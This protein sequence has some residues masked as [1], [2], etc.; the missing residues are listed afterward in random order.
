MN[1]P[2]TPLQGLLDQ[3]R[4]VLAHDYL[5]QMGGAER[6]VASLHRTF[7][8]APIYVS[9]TDR[10]RLLS[11]FDG[12]AIR[13]SWMQR[14]PGIN[15][16]FKKLFPVYPFAFRSF[17]RVAAD[18]AVVSS[19][20]FAKWLRFA[21]DARVFC[22][23]HTPPR[24]FWQADHYLE[25][26]VQSAMLK[27]AAKLFI[28][29]L[30]HADYSAAQD[31]DYFIAN[32]KCVQARIMECYGRK[33]VVIYPPVEV[34]RFAVTGRD[35]GY[36][37]VLSR[38]VAYKGIDRAVRAFSASGR[39]LI[40]V[41]DGPDRSR[42]EAMAGPSVEF[43]GR[44]SEQDVKRYLENCYAF[45]FPG[46]EDFGIAPVEAQ[47]A[48]KPVLA[49]GEGGA[50]ETVVEGVTGLFFHDTSP[51][52]INA[53]ADRFEKVTWVP[54]AIRAH[55]EKFAEAHFVAAMRSFIESKL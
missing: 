49:F 13:N 32:S 3:Q 52:G 6:V 55:A 37:L 34:D 46:L 11:D 44:A 47:A 21:K 41:G 5:M 51:A 18:V 7:P 10:A 2:E 16:H 45:V 24:F 36:Y 19:A 27:A 30:R 26:E 4:V 14:I 8:A 1:M 40:V 54:A 20:G 15:T 53:V 48:G 23:C 25:N 38:L 35:E 31:V 39:R 29:W 12:A 9:A 33:S 43:K 42:L 28:P 17:G 50:L 22:Y